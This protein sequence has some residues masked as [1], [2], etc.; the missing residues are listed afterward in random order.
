MSLRSLLDG[1]R[2]LFRKEQVS[3]E[4]D[5]ELNGFLEMAAEEKMK[6]GM[7]RKE[8]LRT[9]RLERGSIE[10]A[11]EVVRAAGWE[12]LVEMWCQ[13][14]RYGLRMFRKNPG[15]TAV[16]LLTLTLGLGV[17]CAIFTVVNAVLLQPLPYPDSERLVLVQRQFPDGMYPATSSTK[18]LFWRE[19]ARGF[20]AMAGYTFAS[21]GVN[22]T[23]TGEPVRL[24]SLRVSADFFRTIGVQLFLGR[25]FTNDEDRPGGPNTVVLSHNLWQRDFHGDSG[26]VG[27]T[28]RLGGQLCTVVGVAPANF[29]FTPAADLWT[30]LRA[31]PDPHDQTNVYRVLGRLRPEVNY[32]RAD[33]YV[34][35]AGEEFRQ[36]HADLMNDK[37]TVSVRGY[38]DAIVGDVRPAL[39][40]L[41]GA[42]GFVLLIACA[43]LGN[44]LL[45]RATTRR[46]EMA[47][48]L[49]LGANRLRLTRQ[50]LIE[51]T[52]LSITG[53][54]MGLAAAA[55]ALP[56]LLRLTP[57]SLPRLGE[58]R[59][60]W[61]V[62]TFAFIAA[63][64]TG[65]LF[66]LAPAMQG[67]KTGLREALHESIRRT[68][69]SPGAMRLQRLL[70]VGEV[71]LSVVLL[72]GAGLLIQTFWQLQHESPGF[73][74]R[75]VLT[76]Q[77]TLDNQRY[78]KT[79]AVA[80]LE[81]QALARLES[82]PGVEVAATV[83][84]LPFDFGP[85]MNFAIEEN[86]SGGDPS[87]STEWRAITP[88][89]LRTM[90]IPL[91][92]ARNCRH[93]GQ[94]QGVWSH[95]ARARDPLRSCGSSAGWH[96]GYRQSVDTSG[97]ARTHYRRATFARQG[98]AARTA[99]RHEPR[100]TGQFP[101]DGRLVERINRATT[102]Q[103]V[104][105]G[106]VCWSRRCIS[107]SRAVWG[108][109][110]SRRSAHERNR[111]S[112]GF[113]CKPSRGSASCCPERNADDFCRSE[114]R[115][116]CCA[117]PY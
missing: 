5:E 93:R 114:P 29:T 11:K 60:D 70:V 47:V 48:R 21:S 12:C 69:A 115:N 87:G 63:L 62:W 102:L 97:L 68:G 23:G 55:G 103:Y 76:A 61:H 17:N 85:D 104:A 15:F 9:V 89:Y 37:E 67:A 105:A 1:L 30:P 84:N 117:R 2:S 18:F 45:S 106:H 66:G 107:S 19:H 98:C 91:L 44:L 112:N 22:L 81:E 41:F 51:S 57:D 101:N 10:V 71:G 113:G 50:L 79:A 53:A 90:Q 92:D 26:I 34:R 35:A 72:I 32:A 109:R 46:K 14:V 40:I 75:H 7:S 13:D 94:H 116:R 110:L 3:H 108:A 86:P 88:H 39:L 78:S 33:Q 64:T 74:P 100:G 96:D 99:G 52:L 25:S 95:S 56:L 58:V 27:R 54:G 83:S 16:A 24:H 6:Q 80:Q 28:I 49:A 4:L 31:Q 111:D 38:R 77:M 42:V 43:N 59:L 36:Q 73:D 8:A 20:E 65:I 82:L